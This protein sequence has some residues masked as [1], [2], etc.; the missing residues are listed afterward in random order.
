MLGPEEVHLW[1]VQVGRFPD[2][3]HAPAHL[4]ILSDSERD[5]RERFRIPADRWMYG[6]SHA[7]LRMVLAHYGTGPPESLKFSRGAHGKP[8]LDGAGGSTDLEFN[9]T[10]TKGLAAVAVARGRPVGVDAE[11]EDR[12]I[13]ELLASRIFSEQER[14]ALHG[15]SPEDRL[16]RMARLWTLKEA[17]VKALGVGLTLSVADMSFGITDE[18]PPR[19]EPA[20]PVGHDPK[21]WCFFEASHLRPFVVSVAVDNPAGAA[22]ML[23]SFDGETLLNSS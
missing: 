21:R 4:A 17:Y 11:R 19:F 2:S 1:S 23:R 9:L 18:G 10:H 14:R 13:G 5:R 8:A 20:S 16:R 6:I 12:P 15:K 3:A 7:L 22:I